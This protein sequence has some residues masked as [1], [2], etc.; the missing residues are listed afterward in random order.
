M[1]RW[2]SGFFSVMKYFGLIILMQSVPTIFI[3]CI[4]LTYFS[5]V[6]LQALLWHCFFV[7]LFNSLCIANQTHSWL[8]VVKISERIEYFH[9]SPF[10]VILEILW[11]KAW[12]WAC[13][14]LLK[15]M[16][17]HNMFLPENTWNSF[18]VQKYTISKRFSYFKLM[19]SKDLH[20]FQ[21]SLVL[22][23]ETYLVYAWTAHDT[24]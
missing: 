7:L 15:L 18:D 9:I 14:L 3:I 6:L 11:L 13:I 20:Q 17:L 2:R 5:N 8:K 12:N 1:D 10:V 19:R 22:Q 16:Q 23:V 4:L 21:C 24:S